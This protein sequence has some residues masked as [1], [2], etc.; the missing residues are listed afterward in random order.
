M[1]GLSR[2][3]SPTCNN[4]LFEV[5]LLQCRA[6]EKQ[7]EQ[8]LETQ[9]KARVW[10]LIHNTEQPN[11]GLLQLRQLCQSIHTD[12]KAEKEMVLAAVSP[13]LAKIT[14]NYIIS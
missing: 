5:F 14:K 1:T 10:F 6:S 2:S 12:A 7:V 4:I 3:Y 11:A 9:K 8:A 13:L